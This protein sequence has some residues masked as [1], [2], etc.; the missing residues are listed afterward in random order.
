MTQ[1]DVERILAALGADHDPIVISERRP[2]SPHVSIARAQNFLDSAI[3]AVKNALVAASRQR[4][5][6]LAFEGK[7][8]TGRPSESDQDLLRSAILFAGAGLDS[9]IKQLVRDAIPALVEVRPSAQSL[10]QA[11]AR[12]VIERGGSIGSGE[13]VELFFADDSKSYLVHRYIAD[14]TLGSMQSSNRVR[15]IARALGMDDA[16]FFKRVDP[17]KSDRT[18]NKMFVARNE[19]IHQLDL[20][21]PDQAD[22]G[23]RHRRKTRSTTETRALVVE[24]LSVSQVLVT[25]AHDALSSPR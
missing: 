5:V 10:L 14:L 3:F 1:P 18:L 8:P 19:I 16:S 4:A 2:S 7:T 15:D 22:G 23:S 9:T 24:A 25:D 20:L 13:L 21:H 17:D 12:R 11:F 6:R